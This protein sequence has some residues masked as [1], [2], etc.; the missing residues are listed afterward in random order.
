MD[1]I[2]GGALITGGASLLGG[3]LTNQAN[4]Q[5]T[6]DAATT[7]GNF[8]LASAREQMAF[9]ER[10]SNTAYQRAM[11]DMKAAGLNP[12]LAYQQGG[13]SSPV[14][15]SASMPGLA[16]HYEDALG[17]GI[18]SAF[19]FRRLKKELDQTDSNVSLNKAMEA[20]QDAQRKLNESNAKVSEMNSKIM[21][22]ELPAIQQKAKVDLK[23]GQIDE[24]MVTPD[25]ILN[26]VKAGT[27][28]VSD[29][30]GVLRPRITI[31]R[32]EIKLPPGTF[33]KSTVPIRK[34]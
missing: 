21:Q 15:A 1:P 20:T 31:N 6:R 7:A 24:K 23:R 16:P 25:A 26:R 3:I 19:E 2:I 18:S 8:N 22:A 29:A 5:A 17:K 12:M 11:A 27:G 32:G 4:A 28:I 13:A 30:V 14:G 10:M 33:N 34:D 9:Q